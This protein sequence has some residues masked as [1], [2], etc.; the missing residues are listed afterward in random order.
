MLCAGEGTR[1]RPLS[2]STP[3][4]LVPVANRPVIC[5]ILDALVRAGIDEVAIVV[6]PSTERAFRAAFA[7]VSTSV[8]LEFVVQRQPRGIAHAVQCAKGFVGGENFLLYLGDNLFQNGVKG[9]VDSFCQDEA[10]ASLAIVRVDH[11]ERFGVAV[12][13]KGAVQRL[14]EKP[15]DDISPWAIAGAYVLNPAVFDAIDHIVPSQRGELEI[16]DALQWLLGRDLHVQACPVTGWWKDVGLPQDL[17]RANSLLIQEREASR[18][19]SVD[20]QSR[21]EGHVLLSEGCRIARSVIRGPCVIG[22]GARVEDSSVGPNVALGE[23][24]VVCRSSIGDSLI[25]DDA[26]IS[27]V[28]CLANSV[29]GQRCRLDYIATRT[30]LALLIGDDCTVSGKGN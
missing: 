20:S 23:R 6:G 17:I 1:L 12:L 10:A 14:V 25:L 13:E 24:C 16:T 5:W 11:P 30:E 4:H 19:G 2:F 22:A 29:V 15:R 27:D 3:K 26:R 8:Q 21:I 18:D 9:V 28:E 7:E